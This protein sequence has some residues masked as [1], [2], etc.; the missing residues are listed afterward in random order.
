MPLLTAVDFD[1]SVD[2]IIGQAA[3]E[4]DAQSKRCAEAWQS[5]AASSF[6][7]GAGRAHR[8]T[9]AKAMQE[10]LDWGSLNGDQAQPYI[11]ADKA[12]SAWERV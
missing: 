1:D 6:E 5:W 11:L 12:M 3:I 4:Q 2:A 8:Y 9:K 7:R 10:V